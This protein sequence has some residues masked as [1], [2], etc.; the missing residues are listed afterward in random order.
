M[1]EYSIN[2]AND[3]S[4]VIGGR[5]KKFGPFSGEAFYNDVLEDKYIE[6]VENNNKLHIYLDGTSGYG[7]SFLDQSF[8][9][10]ARNY[11]LDKV[12]ANVVLHAETFKW[13]I[14]YINSEIWGEK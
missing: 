8:G 13:I 2:I 7:S 1:E 5:W 4:R 12:K 10:L 6:A 9:E 3:F 14:D 11:G